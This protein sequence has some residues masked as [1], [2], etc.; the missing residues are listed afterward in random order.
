MADWKL[1]HFAD[2]GKLCFQAADILVGNPLRAFELSD[3][4]YLKLG[5]WADDAGILR[6]KRGY[7]ELDYRISHKVR[8]NREDVP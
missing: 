1:N 5:F 6:L 8:F 3:I 4:V 2:A 7:F